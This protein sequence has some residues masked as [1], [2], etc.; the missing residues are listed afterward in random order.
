MKEAKK[1][2]N[3]VALFT[4]QLEGFCPYCNRL[5]FI[6]LDNPRVEKVD[7]CEYCRNPISW[8]KDEKTYTN[9]QMLNYRKGAH[10]EVT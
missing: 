7:Y 6:W 8:G 2:K 10:F 9:E 4:P 1:V 5:V 3:I